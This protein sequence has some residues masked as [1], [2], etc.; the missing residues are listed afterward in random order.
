MGSGV[1]L[2]KEK[3]LLFLLF[4]FDTVDGATGLQAASR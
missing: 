3:Y 2:I 1:Q 4:L